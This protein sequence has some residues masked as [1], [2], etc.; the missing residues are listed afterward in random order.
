MPALRSANIFVRY[1]NI[2]PA[3]NQNWVK[4]KLPIISRFLSQDSWQK[5]NLLLIKSIIF[6]SST[7]KVMYSSGTRRLGEFFLAKVLSEFAADFI[8]LNL[9]N[10]RFRSSSDKTQD[11]FIPASKHFLNL[12]WNRYERESTKISNK[13]TKTPT[14]PA[15]IEQVSRYWYFRHSDLQFVIDTDH[16]LHIYLQ[17]WQVFRVCEVILHCLSN[18]HWNIS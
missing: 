1:Q 12:K 16:C 7:V 2:F 6:C 9:L 10:L 11:G 8:L 17:N 3:S 13:W 4:F 14:E 18:L 15:N 5:L